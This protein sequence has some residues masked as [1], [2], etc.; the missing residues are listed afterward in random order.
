[1][2]ISSSTFLPSNELLGRMS[3]IK[4]RK[5]N[6]IF[7]YPLMFEQDLLKNW[8]NLVRDFQTA[9][10]IAQIKISNILNITSSAVQGFGVSAETDYINPAEILNRS[11]HSNYRYDS[12]LR[13]SADAAQVKAAAE[14]QKNFNRPSKSEYA[15]KIN[16]F[17]SFIKNQILSDPLYTNL[18]PSFSLITI[19][20]NLVEIPLIVGT[21]TYKIS[22]SP[23]YWI[24]FILLSNN[25]K[26]SQIRTVGDYVTRIPKNRFLSLARDA[27]IIPARPLK[28]DT[29]IDKAYN[30]LIR[31]TQ[32]TMRKAIENIEKVTRLDDF[33]ADIGFSTSISDTGAIFSNVI[34]DS[35]VESNE[36]RAKTLATINQLIVGT[37]FPIIQTT[38][39]LI[40]NPAVSVDF[41]ARYTTLL[42]SLNTELPP[43][44]STLLDFFSA[45]LRNLKT[46][47][48][49]IKIIKNNCSALNQLN[50]TNY[51][52]SLNRIRIRYSEVR[53]DVR[54]RN[55]T[56][57]VNFAEEVTTVASS[58]NALSASMTGMLSQL[59]GENIDQFNQNSVDI[60]SRLFHTFFTSVD[61]Y[62]VQ[63]PA[64]GNMVTYTASIY[65]FADAAPISRLFSAIFDNISKNQMN[66]FMRNIILSLAQITNFIF[67]Y[68]SFSYVCEFL[69]IV[70]SKVQIKA[71]DVIEFP[72]YTLV[73]P[74]DYVRTLYFALAARNVSDYLNNT[75]DESLRTFKLTEANLTR[76]ADAIINRLEVPNIVII[77]EKTND[78]YYRWSFSRRTLNINK[79]TMINYIKSQSNI[80]SAF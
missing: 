44:A 4:D 53:D 40:V 65:D 68:T 48:D 29:N 46:Q 67:L 33:E 17:R 60:F 36:M 13:A 35:Q 75:N 79:S 61:T 58:L 7:I 26:I 39:N 74:M 18:R 78:I 16:E 5:S 54:S 38:N 71:K 12:T 72:N 37:I 66:V 55:N 34:T 20:E 77:D 6:L 21:R 30:A 69:N 11:L 22:S 73:I 1:M 3:S 59:T 2:K 28:T 19:E 25:M 62:Q 80:T 45:K 47:D 27:N 15:Y 56:R 52:D 31:D 8:G 43:R 32:S 51:I 70:S 41:N 57:V 64:T 14:A 24:L 49:F 76:I 9:Q 23:L 42:N 63:D 50:G 10:F